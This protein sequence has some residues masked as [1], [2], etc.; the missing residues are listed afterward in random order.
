LLI[1]KE[2]KDEVDEK[3]AQALREERR[4]GKKKKKGKGKDDDDDDD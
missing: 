2:H 1:G 3:V 4:S